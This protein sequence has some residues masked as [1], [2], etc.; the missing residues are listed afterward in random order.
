MS[1]HN[2][3][4]RNNS[5]KYGYERA[6]QHIREAEALSYELGGTD[7]DVKEYFFSLSKYELDHIFSLYGKK[8][9]SVKMNYAM[10]AFPKW[11]SGERKMSGE[12]AERL[13]NLLPSQMPIS[14]KYDLV[15]SLW[16]HCGPASHK[17]IYVGPDVSSEELKSFITN[18]FNEKVN[19]YK[20]YDKL[21]KRFTWLGENDS[22]VVQDLKNHF[23]HL[24]KQQLQELSMGRIDIL[25]KN[26][27]SNQM[28]QTFRQEFP[29]GR[30]I[31]EIEFHP[32]YEG[33]SNNKPASAYNDLS[34][35]WMLIIGI[36][37][38]ITL[39]YS[40]S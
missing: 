8:Y 10:E 1:I 23:L 21:V 25:L 27:R 36:I 31:L 17:K 14:K 33:I 37:I 13:F 12:V 20:I 11:K 38:F 4:R 6:L 34:G 2:T 29:I 3:H 18:H 24:E 22:N 26:L 30:H 40:C 19:S 16:K 32:S 35:I 28:H 7:K 39:L 9:G 15:E 5:R